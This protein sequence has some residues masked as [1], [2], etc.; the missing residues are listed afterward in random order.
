MRRKSD[1]T[2]ENDA[3]D[4][5]MDDFKSVTIIIFH[6]FKYLEHLLSILKRDR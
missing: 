2:S 6:M 3:G 5:K 1:E 4:R